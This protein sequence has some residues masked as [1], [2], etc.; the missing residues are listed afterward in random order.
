MHGDPQLWHDLCARLA[1]LR[2]F[3]RVQAEAGASVVQLFDSWAG[4]LG[5]A[6]YAE[7]P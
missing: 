1:D 7:H 3:L 4:V 6:D 2:A 5:R